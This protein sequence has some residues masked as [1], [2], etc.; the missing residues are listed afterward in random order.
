L[1]KDSTREKMRKN[2]KSKKLFLN[3]IG[4]F[5]LPD[6]LTGPVDGVSIVQPFITKHIKQIV[7]I[8]QGAC[9]Q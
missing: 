8:K 9:V 2:A 7:S 3:T 6:V 4:C 1:V 5:C